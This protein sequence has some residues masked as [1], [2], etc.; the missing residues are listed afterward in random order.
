MTSN[1]EYDPFIFYIGGDYKAKIYNLSLIR[2]TCISIRT[3]IEKL[4]NKILIVLYV[5]SIV[6]FVSKKSSNNANFMPAIY[7]FEVNLD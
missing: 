2:C 1:R 6:G 3:M 7:I 4:S 5:I